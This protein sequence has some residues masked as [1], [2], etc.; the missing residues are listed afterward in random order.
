M[1]MDMNNSEVMPIEGAN[2]WKQLS[3]RCPEHRDQN[4]SVTAARDLRSRLTH[5]RL[6]RHQQRRLF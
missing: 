2:V 6:H 1:D 4:V 5:A 3:V